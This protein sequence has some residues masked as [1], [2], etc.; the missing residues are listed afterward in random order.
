MPH[1][2]H[3]TVRGFHLDVYRHVNNARY[4][5][6]LEE[7]RWHYF[8]NHDLAQF[9]N[10]HRYGMAIVN[11]NIHYRRAALLGDRLQIETAFQSID[12]R[13]AVIRQ[14]IRKSGNSRTLAE[15]DIIFMLIDL[16]SGKAI[17]FPDDL[18]QTIQSQL[19]TKGTAS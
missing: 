19:T 8:D 9:F 4:L 12:H 16:A 5:E 15:A 2:T 11:I 18:R 14:T 7:A 13:R 3:I 17:R 6:F 1:Y 10:N